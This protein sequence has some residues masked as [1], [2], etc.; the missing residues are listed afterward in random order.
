[1]AGTIAM[2]ALTRFEYS[3]KY[4]GLITETVLTLLFTYLLSES[5]L[6]GR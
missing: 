4:P 6:A 2:V 3:N 1:M 5:Q